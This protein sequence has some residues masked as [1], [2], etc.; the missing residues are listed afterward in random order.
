MVVVNGHVT[1]SPYIFS[2]P[3]KM[4]CGKL[5]TNWFIEDSSRNIMEYRKLSEKG[6]AYSTKY[7]TV[8]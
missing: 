3:H 5:V 8:H 4:M 7:V 6:T 2:F 1:S